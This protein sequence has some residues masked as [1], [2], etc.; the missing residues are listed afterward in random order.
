MPTKC[1]FVGLWSCFY[2]T[3][4][5]LGCCLQEHVFVV[6]QEAMASIFFICRIARMQATAIALWWQQRSYFYVAPRWASD[7]DT[8]FSSYPKG[9]RDDHVVSWQSKPV[10]HSTS[11]CKGKQRQLHFLHCIMREQVKTTKMQALWDASKS[12]KGMMVMQ[13]SNIM[14]CIARSNNIDHFCLVILWGHE[15]L[16]ITIHK[17]SIARSTNNNQCIFHVVSQEVTTTRIVLRRTMKSDEDNCKSIFFIVSQGYERLAVI[18][19]HDCWLQEGWW[20]LYFLHRIA[21]SEQRRLHF[22]DQL[23]GSKWTISVKI[24][25]INQR[26]IVPLNCLSNS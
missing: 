20:W 14:C 7:N 16:A 18:A 1:K 21:T 2:V 24:T 10:Y 6:L 3:I 22:L 8:I 19:I 12:C 4:Q 25:G 5:L 13:Q 23:Q 26:V 9:A 17:L 11:Y 15:W